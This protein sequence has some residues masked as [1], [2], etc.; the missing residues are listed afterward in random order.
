MTISKNT[1]YLGEAKEQL[2]IDYTGEEGLEIGFNPKYLMDVLKNLS[3]EEIVFE[4][5]EAN[6]PGVIRKGDEY[7]YVVLPMQLTA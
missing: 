5:N 7:V 2:E 3:D 4:V 1:P 6:K